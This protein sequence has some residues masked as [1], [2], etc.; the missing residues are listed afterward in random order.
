MGIPHS[1]RFTNTPVATG[2]VHTGGGL[3]TGSSEAFIN[4]HTTT[5][6][7]RETGCTS[8]KPVRKL[9][10]ET[11]DNQFLDFRKQS[12]ATLLTEM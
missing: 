7:E 1:V 10:V 3:V 11:V 8:V 9:V 5:G 12:G 2:C 4:V 6:R